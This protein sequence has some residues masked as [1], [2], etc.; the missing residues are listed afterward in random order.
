MNHTAPKDDYLVHYFELNAYRWLYV[1]SIGTFMSLFLIVFQPFGVSNYDPDFHLNLLF[2]ANMLGVGL[3]A[4]VV[5]A[6]SH[7]VLRPLLL[8][9]PSRA[10][11]IVWLI[12]D[13]LLVGSTAFLYY[14]FL[15]NWHDY[16]WS[17]YWRFLPDVA[18]VVIFPIGGFVYYI[19]HQSLA[20]RFVHLT[21]AQA[22]PA[23][24]A[25]LLHLRSENDKEV[26]T[27][28]SDALLFLESQDN[29]VEVVYLQDQQRRSQLIRSSLKRISAMNIPQL[30]RC[31]R[32]Y[33]VNL[34]QV[35]NCRGNRHGL[36]LQLPGSDRAVPVSRRYVEAVLEGL[37][38]ERVEEG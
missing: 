12:W 19:R 5:L 3:A 28:S 17:S 27:V 1:L 22:P 16:S 4:I 29:Y 25:E 14:N 35:R 37:G 8:P 31:H 26:C 32:S 6:A 24:A 23:A 15:G 34:A 9:A 20:S 13:V 7:F 33:I 11:L 30:L 36:K 38:R 18:A 21:M 2:L 10:A